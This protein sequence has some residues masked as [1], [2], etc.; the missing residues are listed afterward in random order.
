MV[1]RP[2]AFPLFLALFFCVSSSPFL[3]N[4]RNFFICVSL[5]VLV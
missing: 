4:D 1:C 2:D 3:V 5:Y